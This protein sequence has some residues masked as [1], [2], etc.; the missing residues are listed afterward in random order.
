[1][2]SQRNSTIQR[3][4][5]QPITL[6]ILANSIARI[7]AAALNPVSKSGIVSSGN[8]WERRSQSYFDTGY[9]VPGK[10]RNSPLVIR[11][12]SVNTPRLRPNTQ[13]AML[14]VIS[15]NC[16]ILQSLD[17]LNT[18]VFFDLRPYVMYV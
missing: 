12:T 16:L 14:S 4:F 6:Q 2:L 1:M 3:V 11:Y 18:V 17:N 15:V 8:A 9:G 7:H 10:E 13:F 5:L